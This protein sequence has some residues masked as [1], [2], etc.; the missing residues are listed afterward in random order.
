MDLRDKT[1][2]EIREALERLE[3][4]HP[5]AQSI[6]LRETF[7]VHKNEVVF[8]AELLGMGHNEPRSY[9]VRTT[10]YKAEELFPDEN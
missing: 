9:G 2:N 6:N 10:S 8:R 7:D 4:F 5:A 1:V 3:A